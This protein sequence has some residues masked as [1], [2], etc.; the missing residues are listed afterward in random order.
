VKC[1]V[2]RSGDLAWAWTLESPEF[3]VGKG[4]CQNFDCCAEFI[5]TRAA[6]DF[7]GDN[8]RAEAERVQ[9]IKLQE[10]KPAGGIQ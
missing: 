8:T 9:A 2:C 3:R 6:D 7:P 10:L 4:R 1:P 5:L